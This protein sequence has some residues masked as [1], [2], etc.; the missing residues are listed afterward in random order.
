MK[1][2]I[3][4]SEIALWYDNQDEYYKRYVLGEEQEPNEL[5]EMGS[6]VHKAIADPKY[7][8]L[9]E[10]R[11]K[12]TYKQIIPIRKCLTKMHK[13]KVPEH[14]VGYYTEVDD[15]KMFC[16][17][18]GFDK[19]KGELSE[20]KSTFETKDRPQWSQYRVDYNK[21]LSF[22]AYA[23]WLNT[24][25]FFHNIHLYWLD[26]VKGNVQHFE[27]ARGI[28]DINYIKAWVMNGVAGMKRAGVW[29]K[30][31]SRSERDL[32]KQNKLTL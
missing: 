27:T 15:L 5:M 16:V 2:N 22:Y 14:E 28:M 30:R 31:L 18:D 8:W 23:Y 11:K 29:S 20:Y 17:F 12:Y 7:P 19:K 4:Y 13:F 1:E 9:E 6:L 32:L 3:S 21:Q 26:L 24:H 10:L 25:G